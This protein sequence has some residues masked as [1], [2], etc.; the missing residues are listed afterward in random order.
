MLFMNF[1]ILILFNNLVDMMMFSM[2]MKC[3][4]FEKNLKRKL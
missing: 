4:V 2:Q 1:R 3:L